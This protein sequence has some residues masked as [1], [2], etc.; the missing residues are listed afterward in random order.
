ME[1]SHEPP[2]EGS[3][4]ASD[5]PFSLHEGTAEGSQKGSQGLGIY[6]DCWMSFD[7]LAIK[8][9]ELNAEYPAEKQK[10]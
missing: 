1:A 8:N 6:M 2:S 9:A 5:E 10:T 4:E 7:I 3:H